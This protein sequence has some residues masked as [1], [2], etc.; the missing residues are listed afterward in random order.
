MIGSLGQYRG[1]FMPELIAL[2]GTIAALELGP[3][4]LHTNFDDL[5]VEVYPLSHELVVELITW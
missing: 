2:I 3:V 1:F 5:T 4:T